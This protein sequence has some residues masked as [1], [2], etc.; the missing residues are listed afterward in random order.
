[1]P[2]SEKRGVPAQMSEGCLPIYVSEEEINELFAACLPKLKKAARRM[3]RNQQDCEDALQEGLLLA[4][5]K[6]H[7]FEGRSVFVCD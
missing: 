2:Q 1:V 5:R 4:F 6:L 3:L 7:Q